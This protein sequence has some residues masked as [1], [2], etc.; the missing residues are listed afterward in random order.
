MPLRRLDTHPTEV[1]L[2]HKAIQ[3]EFLNDAIK[4]LQTFEDLLN[5]FH[6][7]GPFLYSLKTAEKLSQNLWFSKFQGVQKETIGMKWVE[8][9]L[10]LL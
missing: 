5:P 4:L 10:V 9:K 3:K 7:T 2:I 1:E 6:V 8:N